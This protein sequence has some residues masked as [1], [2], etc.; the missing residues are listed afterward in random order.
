M[1]EFR[2]VHI[3]PLGRLF[4]LSV[5]LDIT[6]PMGLANIYVLLVLTVIEKVFQI[7]LAVVTALW[8]TIVLRV[9]YMQPTIHVLQV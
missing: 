4:R 3:A 5:H 8:D 9:K 2:P 6:A 7:E 1:Y